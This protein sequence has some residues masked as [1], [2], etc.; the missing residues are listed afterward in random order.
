MMDMAKEHLRD[1]RPGLVTEDVKEALTARIDF[2]DSTINGCN[3]S[4]WGVRVLWVGELS[5]V[6]ANDVENALTREQDP[7]PL[8]AAGREGLKLL[9]IYGDADQQLDNVVAETQVTQRFVNK[10]VVVIK[11]G[12]HAVFYEF[13]DQVVEEIVAFVTR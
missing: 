13:Q 1:L 2:V 8:F 12:G 4:G 11:G 10:K 9:H 5:H 7:E 3:A 6:N